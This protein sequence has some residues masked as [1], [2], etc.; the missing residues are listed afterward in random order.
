MRS[1]SRRYARGERLGSGWGLLSQRTGVF[2][3]AQL[4][5]A[6][7]KRYTLEN[8]VK[9]PIYFTLGEM[10]IDDPEKYAPVIESFKKNGAEIVFTVLPGLTHFEACNAAYTPESFDFLLGHVLETGR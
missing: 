3:A 6:A 5:S 10:D 4:A 8:V 7:P 9:T 1:S 2:A